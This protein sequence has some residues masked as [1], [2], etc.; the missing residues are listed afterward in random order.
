MGAPREMTD[1]ECTDKVA[2]VTLISPARDHHHLVRLHVTLTCC[3]YMIAQRRQPGISLFF[4]HSLFL[5]FLQISI[6]TLGGKELMMLVMIKY[7][8][9]FYIPLKLIKCSFQWTPN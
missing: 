8:V 2:M 9:L 1:Q 6:I 4:L 7:H 5:Y 3:A